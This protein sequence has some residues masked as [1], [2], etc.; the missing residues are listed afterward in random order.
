MPLLETTEQGLYCPAGDFFV[1]PWRPV[2]RAVVTHAHA[3]HACFGC[4]RYLTSR[5]GQRVLQARVGFD[6]AIDT[7]A[8]GETLLI[9]G[10]NV[11]L[12]P[13]GHILGSAQVRVEHQGEIWVVSG[14][15]KVEPDPTCAAF[16]PVRCHVFVSESTFGLPIY[17]WRPQAEILGEVNAWWRANQ[18]EGKVSVLF[19]YALGKAQRLLAGV[20]RTLGP[21]ACHGA[22]EK[23]NRA[24]R[25]TG[26]DLPETAYV[27]EVPKGTDWGRSLIVAPPSANG[28]GWM[29]RFG[30]SESGFASGWMRVRGARRRRTVDRG[31]VLSDHA[32]WPGLLSAIAA[33]GAERVLLTHGYTAAL[34]RRLGELGVAAETLTTGYQGERDDPSPGEPEAES[35][36]AEA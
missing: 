1:D 11:S 7:L 23:M 24:Y 16:E 33:T 27:G 31:F 6:A 19:A 32:D 25:A 34:A 2:G 17:R 12:H 36:E 8:Y 14:D 5:P 9:N 10:V 35:L 20:D 18:D 4:E 30:P 3:D 13:A 26:I 15:Y 22:V 29:R 21:I 28:T